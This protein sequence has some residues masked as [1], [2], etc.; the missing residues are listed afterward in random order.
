MITISTKDIGIGMM[1]IGS[2]MSKGRI[3]NDKEKT[4]SF[5]DIMN[6]SA[7]AQPA[8]NNTPDTI[9]D[10]GI[11]ETKSTG[12]DNKKVID[13][14]TSG[15]E[16][17]SDTDKVSDS[18]ESTKTSD[19]PSDDKISD[20]DI[21]TYDA[22]YYPQNE[23]TIDM[24]TIQDII[25]QLVQLITRELGITD[26]ELKGA[27]DQAG[28]DMVD[29]LDS[30]TLEQFMLGIQDASKLDM[31]I[32][33]KLAGTIN[34]VVSGLE[35][36][37]ENVAGE[38]DVET[39]ITEAKKLLQEADSEAVTE[40]NTNEVTNFANYAD[41]SIESDNADSSKNMFG[42]NAGED[43]KPMAKTNENPV[44]SN[45]NQAI[46]RAF[47]SLDSVGDIAS[48]E[49]YEADIVRQ[50]VDNIKTNI[51]RTTTS[52]EVVLN[53]ESLGK[54]LVNVSEKDGVMQARIIAEN[55]AAKNAIEAS[56]ANLKEAFDSRELKVE[57]IEVMVGTFE[58]FEQQ[59]ESEENNNSGKAKSAGNGNFS[60]D[61]DVVDEELTEQEKLQAEMMRMSGNRVNYSI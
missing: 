29:F 55:E 35:E 27:L 15:N 18:T 58:S 56:I 59:S 16:K 12:S 14:N 43:K 45:L 44:V 26:E 46:D 17:T 22:A 33:E 10:T 47:E 19:A 24:G 61:G 52:L 7:N 39:V 11:D 49:L 32:D 30:G 37:L 53:P 9:K 3:G 23:E 41:K 1:D 54:V 28:L 38:F 5:A 8:D 48:S 40:N 42:E 50:I 57:A 21:I 13:N 4:D 2:G 60:L 20:S 51:S 36:I 6:L 31:L 34:D 25:T